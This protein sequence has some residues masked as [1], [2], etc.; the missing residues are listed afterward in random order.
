MEKLKKV[1]VAMLLVVLAG[2]VGY[3]DY[4]IFFGHLTT[5][6]ELVTILGSIT[7]VSFL[8]FCLNTK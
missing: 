3:L 1:V 4:C 5:N 8:L 7:S 2:L 6:Q